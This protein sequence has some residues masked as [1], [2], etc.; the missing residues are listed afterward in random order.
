[1]EH[2]SI[3]T[4]VVLCSTPRGAVDGAPGFRGD[5]MMLVEMGGRERTAA[6]YRVL[7]AAAGLALTD[8]RPLQADW[9]LIEGVPA[10]VG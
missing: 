3:P 10:N 4:C 6:E 5:V 8:I 2:S 1:M 9:R 7:F